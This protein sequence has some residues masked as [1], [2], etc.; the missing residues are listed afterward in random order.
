VIV[1]RLGGYS[2]PASPRTVVQNV[3][4]ACELGV[5]CGD[6]IHRAHDDG[7]KGEN[8]RRGAALPITAV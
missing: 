8:K 2:Q 1:A 4:A 6:G 5:D 7:Q 3:R